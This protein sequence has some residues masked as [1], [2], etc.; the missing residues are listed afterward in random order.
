MSINEIIET[1]AAIISMQSK[2]IDKLYQQLSQLMTVEEIDKSV[3]LKTIN[4]IAELHAG[5][6]RLKEEC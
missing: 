6:E 3:E 2:V 4:Q 1:Q 5:L